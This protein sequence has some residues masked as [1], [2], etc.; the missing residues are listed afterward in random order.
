MNSNFTQ[1][2]FTMNDITDENKFLIPKFQRN[3]VWKKKRKVD[4]IKNVRNG[5]PFGVILVRQKN[6]KYELIDGL[7]RVSTIKSFYKDPYEYLDEN[8]VDENLVEKLIIKDCN[9]RNIQPDDNYL[10]SKKKA[11]RKKIF[12]YLKAGQENYQA[13]RS[14][15]ENEGIFDDNGID[16]I[17][18]EI[19]KKFNETIDIRSIPVFA[20]NY[21]GPEQNIPDVFYHLNTGGVQLSKYETYSALWNSRLYPIQDEEIIEKIKNKYNDLSSD[22]EIEVIFDE[23]DLEENGITLFEFCYSISSILRDSTKGYNLVV[24]NNNKTTDPLGFEIMSLIFTGE[25]NRADKLFELLKDVNSDFLIKIKNM[26]TESMDEITSSLKQVVIG[27][28]GQNL[29]SESTYMFYHILMSYIKEYY[30]IDVNSQTV[31]NINSE[32][33]KRDF[34]KYLPLRYI[35][36]SFND[37]WKTNRQ[38]SDLK[39]EIDSIESR[40]RYWFNIR[41]EE[42]KESML[43]F[44]GKQT[45]STKTIPYNV[46]LFIDFFTKL[47]IEKI[48]SMAR[49]FKEQE[50]N[51][52]PVYLDYEHIIPR[53]IVDKKIKD[54]TEYKQSTFP[55]SSLGNICYL[56]VKDN[57][58]KRDKTIYQFSDDRP[59]FTFDSDYLD[60]INYPKNDEIGFINYQNSDFRD[61]YL[62][63]IKNR[64][65]SL[66]NEFINMINEKFN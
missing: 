21:T 53:S 2:Q 61:E 49:Y 4:F 1:A 56:S 13:M 40:R 62:N 63:F 6:N 8:D 65:N 64:V 16:Q 3:V 46:K 51:S 59:A 58:S 38:V 44:A 32:L 19:Y 24:G 47:K 31:E 18:N 48:P 12:E 28:G 5:D 50:I 41:S 55:V 35:Y 57:R 42:F 45:T 10:S 39:R 37:F 54:L 22:S 25:V 36:D 17:I 29:T 14:L 52:E 34:K 66:I 15:H 7:Q 23:N 43:E 60:F 20:I 27:L 11:L 26:L 30:R 9:L 33:K